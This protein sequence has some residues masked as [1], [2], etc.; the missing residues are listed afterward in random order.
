MFFLLQSVLPAPVGTASKNRVAASLGLLFLT[1]CFMGSARAQSASDVIV[2]NSNSSQ[3]ALTGAWTTSVATPG[4]YGSNYLH[5]G[6]TGKGT[7]SVRF[8][9]SLPVAATY[10]L[11]GRW[12]G[13]ANRATNVP[14]DIVYAGGTT[15]VVV[16][17]Q[18]NGGQWVSLGRFN[19]A[20]GLGASAT[21]RTTGTTA[22]VIADAF[23]WVA[24]A[25]PPP[26]PPDAL[27][28]PT[29]LAASVAG[30]T[31]S[32]SWT[33]ASTG[34]SGYKVQRKIGSNGAWEDRLR[35]TTP[36]QS[37]YSESG[38]AAGLY[39]YRVLAYKASVSNGP[40]SDEVSATI[41]P[42]PTAPAAPT[43]LTATSGNA[44]AALSWSAVSGAI[45]YRLF[46]ATVSGSYN[47]LAPVATVTTPNATDTNLSNG[48]PYFYVVRAVNAAGE[49]SN[50]SEASATPTSPF[51]LDAHIRSA[52]TD[53]TWLGVGLINATA[54]NQTLSGAIGGGATQS[55]EVKIVCSGGVGSQTVKVSVPDWSAFAVSNWS[56]RFYDAATNGNDITAQ[57]TGA[58][59]WE[60]VMN[61]GDER[62]LRVEV[63]APNDAAIGAIQALTIRA[64]ANSTSETPAIDVVKAIWKAVETNQP[65]ALIRVTPSEEE[66][67]DYSGKGVYNT[68]GANQS[69]Q[70][71]S[72]PG[73]PVSFDVQLQN[74]GASA[75]PFVIK[76]PAAPTGW[77]LQLFDALADGNDIS[78]AAQSAAGWNSPLLG[79]GEQR[80]LRLVMTPA[81]D[82]FTSA[83]VLLSVTCGALSDSVGAIV[84][85]Q[86]IAG[87][88]Y[89]LDGGKTWAPVP[90]GDIKVTQ[91]SLIA[92]RAS[93]GNPDAPWP[94]TPFKPE[95][96]QGAQSHVGKEVYLHFP[97]LTG[98][99]AIKISAQ[100]GN[101]VTALVRVLPDPDE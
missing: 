8:A 5:D 26:P 55:S 7:K 35:G 17:Q 58:G 12:T 86:S 63:S 13:D 99:D 64:S 25:A 28:A 101:A 16:N 97:Q 4:Y 67:A 15:T 41:A 82:T 73:A 50:S 83:S 90:A 38:L 69:A 93:R 80:E 75:A 43:A 36:N 48:T 46:R 59:G 71:L 76:L 68:N 27:N 31:V 92:F 11:F 56:A 66:D 29:G 23:R 89:S 18:Q 37:S 53:D 61:A 49:S 60:V 33:D 45:S 91:W 9:P 87:V 74:E 24:D 57:I 10:E 70:S 34:E 51:V 79:S 42:S 20:A 52:A 77:S 72:V 30:S 6:N 19:C 85:V 1:L 78:A 3:V 22:Y 62:T 21:I 40:T 95:W 94:S 14:I 2:D 32:L 98:E 88:E 44:Q 84:P 65:D 47:A 81:A 39:F 100:C 96:K 54:E